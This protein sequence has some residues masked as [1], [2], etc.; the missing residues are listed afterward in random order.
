MSS[1][2]TYLTVGRAGLYR[3][4]MLTFVAAKRRFTVHLRPEDVREAP[5]SHQK[6]HRLLPRSRFA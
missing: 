6:L 4:V 1:P 5:Q 2:F 3:Q